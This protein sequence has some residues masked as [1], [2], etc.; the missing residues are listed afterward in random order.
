LDL[1]LNTFH[2]VT[3]FNMSQNV[4][5]N[6]QP[7]AGDTSN[8]PIFHTYI[9]RSDGA[10]MVNGVAYVPR[11][12]TVTVATSVPVSITPVAGIPINDAHPQPTVPAVVT[13]AIAQPYHIPLGGSAMPVNFVAFPTYSFED[14]LPYCD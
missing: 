8:G 6:F 10:I 12:N 4:A 13:Q 3:N 7:Q 1:N 11:N 2:L 14:E 9:P 5:Q